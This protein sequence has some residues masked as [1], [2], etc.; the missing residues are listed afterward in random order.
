[1]PF[2]ERVKIEAKKKAHYSCVICHKPFVEVHHIIPQ[3]AGGSDSLDNAAPLCGYCHDVYGENPSKRKQIR[4]MR[5]FW[6][7][8]C[9]NAPASSAEIELNIKL[10]T[11]SEAL[12]KSLETQEYH[13]AMLND[14]KAALSDYH[15]KSTESLSS[16]QTVA[17]VSKVSGI[18]LPFGM[19]Q[20]PK[21]GETGI[22][23]Y[24]QGR[25]VYL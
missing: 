13:S 10:D 19:D 20:D 9:A 18:K 4:E 1:M 25:K 14:V 11:I 7:E 6:W 22:L 5:D 23:C 3:H 8:F 12:L 21:T 16:A 2:P 15:T 24:V 17:E